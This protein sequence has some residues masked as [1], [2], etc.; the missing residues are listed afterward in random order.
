M[1]E[2]KYRVYIPEFSEL[3]YFDLNNFDHSDRY[4]DNPEHPVQQYTGM[5]DKYGK[6]IYEGDIVINTTS[7]EEYCSPAVIVWGKYEFVGFALAYKRNKLEDYHAPLIHKINGVDLVE[8]FNLSK[9]GIYQ[10]VGNVS[11]NPE[12]LK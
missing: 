4:L 2:L 7:K 10:I 8:E 5:K 1:R 9:I 11:E 6:D 12:L 3:V